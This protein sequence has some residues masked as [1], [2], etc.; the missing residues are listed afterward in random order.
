MRLGPAS[1]KPPGTGQSLR[2]PQAGH[3]DPLRHNSNIHWGTEAAGGDGPGDAE[4]ERRRAAQQEYQRELQ[5]QIQEKRGRDQRERELNAARE[6]REEEEAMR[7]NPYGR[8]GGGAPLK[9]D[10]GEVLAD[11]RENTHNAIASHAVVAGRMDDGPPMNVRHLLERTPAAPLQP[12]SPVKQSRLGGGAMA[13]VMGGRSGSP[14]ISESD[15]KEA[16]RRRY[17][18]DLEQQMREKQ[19][20]KQREKRETAAYEAKLEA[21]AGEAYKYM[22][23]ETHGKQ[24][25]GGRGEPAVVPPPEPSG[26]P[27]MGATRRGG[28]PKNVG[29]GN[30]GGAPT[31]TMKQATHGRRAPLERPGRIVQPLAA[32]EELDSLPPPRGAWGPAAAG[33]D[34]GGGGGGGDPSGGAFDI[35]ERGLSRLAALERQAD[36][37]RERQVS[38]DRHRDHSIERALDRHREWQQSFLQQEAE[39]RQ[40]EGRRIEEEIA[41]MR[42][43]F[44][45]QQQK[46]LS[47][48]EEQLARLRA[49]TAQAQFAPPAAL[50]ALGAALP[51]P[52]QPQ[53]ALPDQLRRSLNSRSELMEPAAAAALMDA[54]ANA[55]EALKSAGSYLNGE[56][57]APA[58]VVPPGG[59]PLDRGADERGTKLENRP[60]DELDRLL[61]DFLAKGA[62]SDEGAKQDNRTR[63]E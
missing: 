16:A 47:Q 4:A 23:P 1:L 27:G 11:L 6:R 14:P 40:G 30:G 24:Y 46:I 9:S 2:G 54:G 18:S 29:G 5:A 22:A 44:A 37:D 51:P 50:A 8:G 55:R 58:F 59:G 25:G 38:R 3:I 13:G 19:E 35:S 31:T 56:M 15:R 34:A 42:R 7:Y 12:R 60:P 62:F 20:R 57:G 32:I 17:V 63:N 36:S 26:F 28:F 61:N 10:E 39:R 45:A 48:V 49:V 41:S 52:G 43:E 53:N 33:N 21:E